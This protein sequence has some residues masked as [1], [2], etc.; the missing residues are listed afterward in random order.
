MVLIGAAAPGQAQS[1]P[2]PPTRRTA[3]I[4]F[5]AGYGATYDSASGRTLPVTWLL[6]LGLGVH[7]RASLV[8]EIGGGY[9]R[10]TKDGFEVEQ[11]IHTFLGGVRVPVSHY[12][13][14]TVFVQGLVGAGCYCGSTASGGPALKGVALQGGAGVD[15]PLV[16]RLALRG[17]F[18]VRSVRDRGTAFTQTRIAVGAVVGWPAH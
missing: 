6:S 16:P 5:S 3:P 8:G 2:A 17:Q 7:P 4:D 9:A 1:L 18:D 13:T 15:V 11:R 14:S 10:Y 12:R